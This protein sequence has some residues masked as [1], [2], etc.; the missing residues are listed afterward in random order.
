LAS[1]FCFSTSAVLAATAMGGMAGV[2]LTAART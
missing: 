1:A 2:N